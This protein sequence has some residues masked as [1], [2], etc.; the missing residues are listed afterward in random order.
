MKHTKQFYREQYKIYKK[1]LKAYTKKTGVQYDRYSLKEFTA[2]YEADARARVYHKSIAKTLAY[3]QYNRLG[4]RKS[5][6]KR[7]YETYL[8]QT[9]NPSLSQIAEDLFGGI[10]DGLVASVTKS[11]AGQARAEEPEY[12]SVEE[13]MANVTHEQLV[14]LYDDDMR[15]YYVKRKAQGAKST[16]IAKEIGSMYFGSK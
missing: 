12:K 13:F 1:E 4:V 11:P 16:D 5:V 7:A 9:G 8:Q 14:N 10:D 2:K 6:A 15:A 3:M